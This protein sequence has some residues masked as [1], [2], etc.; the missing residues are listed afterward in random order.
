M[1]NANNRIRAEW[2]TGRQYSS[3]GQIIRAV[4]SPARD[5]ITFHDTARHIIGRIRLDDFDREA[6][7]IPRSADE[8]RRYVMSAYD[9]GAYEDATS[10]D[11]ARAYG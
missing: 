9:A 11:L 1:T 7:I 8:L 10:G 5:T 3:A 6:D 2:N 4:L